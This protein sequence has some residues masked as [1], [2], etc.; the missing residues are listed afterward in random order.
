[1]KSWFFSSY[2][3]SICIFQNLNWDL[4]QNI[5]HQFGVVCLPSLKRA[6]DLTYGK[7]W[8]IWL[9]IEETPDRTLKFVKIDSLYDIWNKEKRVQNL[10]VLTLVWIRWVF[11]SENRERNILCKKKIRNQKKNKFKR[12]RKSSEQTENHHQDTQLSW[13]QLQKLEWE[14]P[15]IN[16]HFPSC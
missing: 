7:F 10:L 8:K 2:S 13:T 4:Y 11:W 3:F 15:H 14:S 1:M 6:W 9:V 16:L 12:K 5:I